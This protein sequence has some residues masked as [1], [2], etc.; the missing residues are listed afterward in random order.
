[1]SILRTLATSI[2]LCCGLCHAQFDDMMGFGAASTMNVSQT[3]SVQS[4]QPGKPFYLALHAN[5]TAP[6]HAYWKNP[7]TV[8]ECMTAE[9]TAPA[10]FEVKGPYWQVPHKHEGVLGVAYT[11]ENAIVVWEVTPAADAP[12]KASFTMS[13]TAQTCSDEGCNPPETQTMTVELASGDGA[14]NPVWTNEDKKVEVLGDT[15]TTVSATQEG[16]TV[17]LSFTAE[18]GQIGRA[19]V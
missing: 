5:F 17:S 13:A 19:H 2:L 6:W 15:P 11:Y 14:P 9:L 16:N 18:P 10:G 7:G 1:M 4:Y 3:P 8:G 12:A